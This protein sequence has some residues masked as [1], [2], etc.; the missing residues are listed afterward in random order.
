MLR[1]PTHLQT[2]LLSHWGYIFYHP[3]FAAEWS[4]NMI[5]S[6]P[7][8]YYALVCLHRFN[9]DCLILFAQFLQLI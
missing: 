2:G 4:R 7:R 3:L 5:C 1:P 8:L 9:S 6:L